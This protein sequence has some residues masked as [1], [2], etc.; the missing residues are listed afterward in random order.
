MLLSYGSPFVL[1]AAV[2]I[3][4]SLRVISSP[5]FH[6]LLHVFLPSQWL[7]FVGFF[8]FFLLGLLSTPS[9]P[10][11]RGSHIAQ[12]D[13]EY[14]LRSDWPSPLVSATRVL[15]L[16]ACTTT[17]G[18]FPFDLQLNMPLF[19][20]VSHMLRCISLQIHDYVCVN[21]SSCDLILQLLNSLSRSF[22]HQ[23]FQKSSC[24]VSSPT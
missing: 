4:F 6:T 3:P 16:Q 19:T 22:L 20:W 15:G 12:I 10:I 24:S 7:S 1:P 9:F 18:Y 17:H 2:K 14:T 13:L 11:Q 5:F 21:K 23:I 8:L